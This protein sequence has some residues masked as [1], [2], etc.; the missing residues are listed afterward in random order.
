MVAE[1]EMLTLEYSSCTASRTSWNSKVIKQRMRN[2]N[3]DVD[4]K[5]IS[6]RDKQSDSNVSLR[7][8][9]I[10]SWSISRNRKCNVTWTC[11]SM[12]LH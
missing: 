3:E 1:L 12:D 5:K 6:C 11:N 7:V 8:P 10:G 9:Q 4:P 2:L